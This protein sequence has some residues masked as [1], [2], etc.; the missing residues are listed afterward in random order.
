MKVPTPSQA[1]H[2]PFKT[3]PLR[4]SFGPREKPLG[5]SVELVE[6]LESRRR[7]RSTSQS[8]IPLL[9][10]TAGKDRMASAPQSNAAPSAGGEDSAWDGDMVLAGR[11]C[12]SGY[13][14]HCAVPGV[15]DGLSTAKKLKQNTSQDI[16]LPKQFD[17]PLVVMPSVENEKRARLEGLRTTNCTGSDQAGG[18]G[19]ALSPKEALSIAASGNHTDNHQDSLDK[20]RA[21]AEGRDAGADR[22]PQETLT[23]LRTVFWKKEKKND[24]AVAPQMPPASL[25]SGRLS[26]AVGLRIQESLTQT[27]AHHLDGGVRSAPSSL[28]LP[29]KAS[30]PLRAS[31]LGTSPR[32]VLGEQT[33]FG[34]LQKVKYHTLSLGRKKSSPQ[35]SF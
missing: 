25:V 30:H 12:P 28:H 16:R 8:I 17:L 13:P 4:W 14:K 11:P 32:S 27:P 3:M 7:P 20:I 35:S 19:T 18:S 2:G 33:S 21:N 6:Y 5:A 9:T 22:S 31:A 24:R 23:L 29:R 34:T 10:G 1:K 26:P 15:P